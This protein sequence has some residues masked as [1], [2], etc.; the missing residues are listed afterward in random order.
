ME[1]FV[2]NKIMVKLL[3]FKIDNISSMMINLNLCDLI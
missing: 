1:T 3:I 2:K